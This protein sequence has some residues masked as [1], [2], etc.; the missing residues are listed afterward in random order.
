MFTMFTS[1]STTVLVAT[2][3]PKSQDL[4]MSRV[5]SFIIILIYI[6]YVF[7]TLIAPSGDADAGSAQGDYEEVGGSDGG[8]AEEEEE[9][10][11]VTSL[12][13]CIVFF[14]LVLVVISVASDLVSDSIESTAKD[15]GIPSNFV[16]MIII[17]VLTNQEG[18][19]AYN[20]MAKGGKKNYNLALGVAMQA[21]MQVCVFCVPFLIL[22]AWAMGK[23]MDLA[24]S[25]MDVVLLIF[26][27]WLCQN[28]LNDGASDWYEGCLFLILYV[29]IGICYFFA[30][31]YEHTPLPN[32]HD[33]LSAALG[34]G[35]HLRTG[36]PA[37]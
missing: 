32:P 6:L 18:F 9:E 24:F 7:K 30:G 5:A 12:I 35:G 4:M 3:F 26:S 25:V 19:V 1:I 2:D 29:L 34:G 21:G 8:E 22:V 11:P 27:I 23:D 31:D 28:M 17:P 14:M 10:P 33:G 16:G 13:T 15:L 36:T 37:T 20:Y